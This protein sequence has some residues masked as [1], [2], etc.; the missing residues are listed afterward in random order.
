MLIQLA[1]GRAMTKAKRAAETLF[2]DYHR[3]HN[4]DIRV[5][6]IFNTF[7]PQMKVDD[8]RVVSNFIMQ[9]LNN[10]PI[11]IYG[12]GTQTR[13]FCYVDDLIIGLIRM[14][15]Q[16]ESIG[17]INLGNP[18]EYT[19]FELAKKIISLTN[20]NSKITYKTLP[21]NDPKKRKPDIALAKKSSLEPF[22]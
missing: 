15:N 21:E 5:V 20:S 2:F 22:I 7:G 9:A 8:G 11:T 13:S 17:P 3:Q 14:M 4:L 12:D 1:L 18:D 10:E 16:N 19:I 6:R